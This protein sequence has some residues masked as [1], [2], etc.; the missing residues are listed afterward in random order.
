MKNIIDAEI[1]WRVFLEERTVAAETRSTIES[2]YIR[3]NPEFNIVPELDDVDF[4]EELSRSTSRGIFEETIEDL[5]L[6]LI[7]TTFYFKKLI[8]SADEAGEYNCHGKQTHLI[9]R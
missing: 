2:R 7:A 1:A 8:C 5:A 3:L 9:G 6:H 4:L